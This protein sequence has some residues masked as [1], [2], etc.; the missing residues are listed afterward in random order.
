MALDSLFKLF[1]QYGWPGMIAVIII[2]VIYGLITRKEKK[3]LSVIEKGFT[4]ITDAMAKQNDNL[5]NAITISNEKTQERL[6]SLVNKTITDNE[7]IKEQR[8]KYSLSKREEVSEQVDEILFDILNMSHAQRVIMIEFHNSKENLDGLG[9][10]WYDVQ[11]EKQQKGIDSIS[12]KVRNLQATNLRPIVKRVN[13]SKSHIIRLS[14][15]DIEDIYS[16]STVLYSYLKEKDI[17]VSNVIYAGVYNNETNSMIGLIAIEYQ[18]EFPYHDDFIDDF[19]LKEK[20]TLIEH[21]YNQATTD[22][23]NFKHDR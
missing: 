19:T 16:E 3:S 21:L 4:N 17:N 12:T 15:K 8:H 1:E 22:I 2:L 9:F 6:F 13:N 11:H 5:I 10:L 20:C 23:N 14:A 7:T 18:N